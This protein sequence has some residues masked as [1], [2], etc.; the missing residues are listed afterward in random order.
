MIELPR[1]A[2][3]PSDAKAGGLVV[4]ALSEDPDVG[5][6]ARRVGE[7][8]DGGS[9][10]RPAVVGI[11]V[12]Q[13]GTYAT[14]GISLLFSDMLGDHVIGTSSAGDQPVRWVPRVLFLL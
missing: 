1:D 3:C 6:P 13:F 7:P 4:E 11:G 5:L 12:N 10:S 8:E 2:A 14:G 9:T